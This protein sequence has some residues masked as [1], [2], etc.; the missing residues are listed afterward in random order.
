MS[1]TSALF[2]TIALPAVL[3][4]LILGACGPA[5]TDAQELQRFMSGTESQSA[6]YIYIEDSAH[7]EVEVRG[8]IEDAFRHEAQLFLEGN[9]IVER[10]V[11][12]DAMAIRVV[13]PSKLQAL[14]GPIADP[15]D[16]QVA[17][18]LSQGKWVLDPAGAP[19][20]KPPEDVEKVGPDPMRDALNV[21]VYSNAAIEEAVGIR[22]FNP[23]A[24]DYR[25]QD[26]P[27]PKPDKKKLEER[28]D[29]QRPPLPRRETGQQRGVG[30]P[31]FRKLSFYVE[32]GE[33][34]RVLEDIDIEGHEEFR[35]AL[36][37][38]RPKFLLRLLDELRSG[39]T[40]ETIRVRQMSMTFT[41]LGVPITVSLPQDALTG[42]LRGLLGSDGA[43]VLSGRGSEVPV[44]EEAQTSA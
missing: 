4:L 3:A 23:D 38:G 24:L 10:V 26:D 33:I 16:F 12:D 30:T 13:D 19:A 20:L 22:Q 21:F 28:Y 40:A 31:H 2:R 1:K 41:S 25:P 7:G 34:T 14:S 43:L 6:E 27:F 36:K 5:D 17:S 15:V 39:R 8:R 37:T 11:S 35:R 18:A 42:N 32:D 9:L 44:P 29:L